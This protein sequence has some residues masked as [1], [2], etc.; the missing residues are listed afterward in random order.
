MNNTNPNK[1][2]YIRDGRRSIGVDGFIVNISFTQQHPSPHSLPSD[3]A[4]LMGHGFDIWGHRMMDKPIDGAVCADGDDV[5][6][7]YPPFVHPLACANSDTCAN[8]VS[9]TV[10]P[11]PFFL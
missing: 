6:N 11:D 1:Y 3:C 5:C 2:R 8:S 7:A 10:D 9:D 4:A